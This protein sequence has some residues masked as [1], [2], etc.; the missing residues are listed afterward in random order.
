MSTEI[1]GSGFHS[2]QLESENEYCVIISLKDLQDALKAVLIHFCSKASVFL[3]YCI[4]W[5]YDRLVAEYIY[6]VEFLSIFEF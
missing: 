2:G 5:N 4:Y 1:A 6:L 3:Q